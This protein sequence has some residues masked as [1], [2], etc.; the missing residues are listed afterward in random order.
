MLKL[1]DT[2]EVL[3]HTNNISLKSTY[4]KLVYTGGT[5]I[6][7]REKFMSTTNV[8]SVRVY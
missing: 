7:H 2:S 5:G 4:L 6:T 8:K 1:N 3:Y